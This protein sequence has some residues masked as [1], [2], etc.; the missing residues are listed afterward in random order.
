MVSISTMQWEY[1]FDN[2]DNEL[3]GG[4]FAYVNL[5]ME[6]ADNSL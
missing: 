6:R 1:T 3:K 2:K 5:N 4:S